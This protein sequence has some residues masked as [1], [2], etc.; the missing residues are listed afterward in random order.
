MSDLIPHNPPPGGNLLSF[1]GGGDLATLCSNSDIAVIDTPLRRLAPVLEFVAS[2]AREY[3]ALQTALRQASYGEE[4]HL[5]LYSERD[6]LFGNRQRK[7][8]DFLLPR[9]FELDEAFCMLQ[10]IV[11][12][13][14]GISAA[15]ALQMLSVLCAGTSKKRNDDP[16]TETFMLSCA[17]LFDPAIDSI[18]LG[19][20][21]WKPVPRHPVVVALAIR[22]LMAGNVFAPTQSELADACRRVAFRLEIPSLATV[23]RICKD[24]CKAHEYLIHHDIN[25]CAEFFDRAFGADRD[26]R[27]AAHDLMDK[28]L[29]VFS[30]IRQEAA[31]GWE[32]E[33]QETQRRE[34]ELLARLAAEGRDQLISLYKEEGLSLEYLELYGCL[35]R[36]GLKEHVDRLDAADRRFNRDIPESVEEFERL[37]QEARRALKSK[38]RRA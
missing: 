21:L 26:K 31:K 22:K 1:R 27:C 28:F 32:Q 11:H 20:G 15:V 23:A 7:V 37:E 13:K 12:G 29:Y 17:Q 6:K 35:L 30:D 38:M 36:E 2:C 14:E 5:L 19:T 25:C 33:K 4:T 10:S 34:T 8:L 24:M 9:L 18:A 16:N 3:D